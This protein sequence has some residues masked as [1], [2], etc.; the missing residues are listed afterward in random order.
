MSRPAALPLPGASGGGAIAFAWQALR[1]ADPRLWGLA[2]LLT[3]V[4]V[5]QNIQWLIEAADI[6]GLGRAVL[7]R[8]LMQAWIMFVMLGAWV[9]ADAG[10][11]AR[12]ARPW[13][14]ML[15]VLAGGPVAAGG[16]ILI[17]EV[18]PIR[19][20]LEAA[21]RAKGGTPPSRWLELAASTI[22]VVVHSALL[23]AVLEVVRRRQRTRAALEAAAAEQAALSRRMLESRLEAMQ[24]QVEPQFLFDSLV[25]VEA[26]YAR[27]PRLAGETLDDLIAFL[28]V[29]LPRLR[30][31]GSTLAD[32]FALVQAY[33]RVLACLNEGAPR[34]AIDLPE[35][36]AAR[37]FA[38][39]LLLP[40]LQRAVRGAVPSTV[41]LAARREPACLVVELEIA[42]PG[43]CSEDETLTRVRERLLGLYGTRA[44][45]ACTESAALTL[46]TITVDDDA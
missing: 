35:A 14:V 46:L 23:V 44:R 13:R 18:F 39:M 29:A 40:L 5:A 16:A 32:E 3:A 24:A 37:R 20:A 30:E 21:L 17:G 27:D 26:L 8:V 43:L 12:L 34:L 25:A 22:D 15:A 9:I 38:P 11:D 33:A 45:L 31:S 10:D 4:L 7:V 36:L 19:E 41:A 2:L 42:R 6:I 1:R 28:R